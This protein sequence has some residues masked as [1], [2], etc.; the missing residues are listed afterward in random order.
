MLHGKQY[1][2]YINMNVY[3]FFS[4]G[5]TLHLFLLRAVFLSMLSQLE[6]LQLMVAVPLFPRRDTLEVDFL[7][8]VIWQQL[9][10][11]LNLLFCDSVIGFTKMWKFL[12]GMPC[13]LS[14]RV[15]YNR[16]EQAFQHCKEKNS[17]IIYFNST[18][19][20]AICSF[21]LFQVLLWVCLKK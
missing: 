12:L 8:A 14:D 21:T 16:I 2:I 4:L 10:G 6:I 3:V 19:T 20:N 5:I 11:T 18:D 7:S 1:N 15:F 17:E 9:C 13:F